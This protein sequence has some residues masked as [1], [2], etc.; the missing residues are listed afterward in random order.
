MT[1]KPDFNIAKWMGQLVSKYPST[2]ENDLKITAAKTKQ[3]LIKATPKKTGRT[4]QLW[5][6]KRKSATIYDITNK[7]K[8]AVFLEEGT[9][10]HGPKK[11]QIT[12]K[13]AGGFLHFPIIQGNTIVGWV[14]TKS[15][16]GIKAVHM[17]KDTIPFTQN[18]LTKRLEASIKKLWERRTV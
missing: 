10:I 8:V 16:A 18:F 2:V 5:E 9:G 6:I 11:R 7:D 13:K 15:V 17:V 14:R 4:S 1:V 12:A 3:K